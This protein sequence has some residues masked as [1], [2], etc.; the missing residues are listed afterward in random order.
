[1]IQNGQTI[2]LLGFGYEHKE[3]ADFLHTEYQVTIDVYDEQNVETPN[4]IRGTFQTLV[5]EDEYDLVVKTPGIPLSKVHDIPQEKLTNAVDIFLHLTQGT[6]VGVTGTKGKSTICSIVHHIL[7][8]SGKKSHLV[9]NIGNSPFAHLPDSK[10]HVYVYEMSSYQCEQLTVGPH[11]AVLSNLFHDHISH[12]GSFQKYKEAKLKI[13]TQQTTDDYF[14]TSPEFSSVT[15]D[16]HK[17][18]I[19]DNFTPYETKL[20]GQHNQYNCEIAK[21]VVGLLGVSE[22]DARTHIGSVR[23]LPGRLERVATRQGID[24]YDDALATVPEATLASI[25]AL[26]DI[27]V[28]IVGGEDRGIDFSVLNQYLKTSDIPYIIV[29]PDSGPKI[30]EGVSEDKLFTANSMQEA[31][32]LV[33]SFNT[34]GICLLSTASPSFSLFKNYKDRSEQYLYWINILNKNKL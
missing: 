17:I 26:G 5:L 23:A 7:S 10:E 21:E 33:Y 22:T 9:G 29:F 1:M 16:A 28:L 4:F 30:V 31:I 11:I 12:H 32:E 6:V 18:I 2:A 8:K 19:E 34:T 13:T 27:S 3:L 15:T 24:F 25:E 14:V 20:L